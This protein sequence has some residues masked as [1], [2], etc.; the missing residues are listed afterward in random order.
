MQAP[1]LSPT[2]LRVHLRESRQH[3][4]DAEA[5][6]VEIAQDSIDDFIIA[7]RRCA[8][9]QL[10]VAQPDNARRQFRDVRMVERGRLGKFN[11]ETRVDPFNQ[12]HES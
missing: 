3:V 8:Y 9:R 10:L 6:G 4:A 7:F 12:R 2:P 5:S 11:R 1:V